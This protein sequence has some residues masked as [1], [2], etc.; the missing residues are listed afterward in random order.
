MVC[1]F[2]NLTYYFHACYAILYPKGI[3]SGIQAIDKANELLSIMTACENAFDNGIMAHT[4]YKFMK[5]LSK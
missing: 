2:G 4:C 5:I 3:S 1:Q